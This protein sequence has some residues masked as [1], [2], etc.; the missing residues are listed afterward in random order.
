LL[1]RQAKLRLE[2]DAH[3]A[4]QQVRAVLGKFSTGILMLQLACFHPS[5]LN[6]QKCVRHL[7]M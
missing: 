4:H 3:G 2:G 7:L 6:L 1:A 5:L